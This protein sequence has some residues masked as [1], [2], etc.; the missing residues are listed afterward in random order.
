M[1]FSNDERVTWTAMFGDVTF[2]RIQL[3]RFL[4]PS[5]LNYENKKAILI[6]W[7]TRK[8]DKVKLLRWTSSFFTGK[9]AKMNHEMCRRDVVVVWCT[10][11]MK[12][13]CHI[14]LEARKNWMRR[15]RYGIVEGGSKTK[16][17][18]LLMTNF[19]F[20]MTENNA[21]EKKSK[22]MGVD[23]W[24]WS[25]GNKFEN[26]FIPSKRERKGKVIEL[27]HLLQVKISFWTRV[28]RWWHC[29]CI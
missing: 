28:L 25:S 21:Q 29:C 8:R 2:G 1:N 16:R 5:Y 22:W 11:T 13:K 18:F 26:D 15:K 12:E 4:E 23:G 24:W 7:R 10:T 27:N 9:R 3:H 19:S 14:N 20:F 17:N 6:N